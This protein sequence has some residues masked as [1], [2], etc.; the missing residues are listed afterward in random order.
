MFTNTV[1][2]VKIYGPTAYGLGGSEPRLWNQTK[3]KWAYV[4]LERDAVFIVLSS[5][6]SSV[7]WGW[8]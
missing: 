5:T 1:L 4:T 8:W 3:E 7:K 6:S 2:W